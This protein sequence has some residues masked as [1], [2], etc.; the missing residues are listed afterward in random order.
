MRVRLSA[1]IQRGCHLGPRPHRY[2]GVDWGWVGGVQR[3]QA[4]APSA[5][6]QQGVCHMHLVW[7]GAGLVECSSTLQPCTVCPVSAGSVPSDEDM[8][9][10]PYQ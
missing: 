5:M 10:S 6:P 2:L 7:T 9:E 4:C 3:A 8:Q 1:G